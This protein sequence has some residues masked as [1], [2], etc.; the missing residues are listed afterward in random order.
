[1]TTQQFLQRLE[2]LYKSNLEISRAKNKDYA[3]DGDPFKNF[4]LCEMLGI[5]SV[6]EGMLVRITDKLSRI[7]NLLKKEAEVKDESILDTLQDLSNYSMI[8]RVYLES[9]KDDKILF[10][11]PSDTPSNNPIFDK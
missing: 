6:E 4:K 2:E 5:C 8:M 3:G 11:T 7:S 10:R 1:M 9:K